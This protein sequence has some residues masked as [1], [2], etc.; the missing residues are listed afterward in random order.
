[1]KI[2]RESRNMFL[3]MLIG[4][5]Y[6]NPQGTMVLRHCYAQKEYLEFKKNLLNSVGIKTSEIIECNNNGYPGVYLY[7]RVYKFSKAYRKI[8]YTPKKNIAI[9]KLLNKLTPLGLAIWYMDDGGLSQKKKN[10]KVHANDLMLNTHLSKEENQ[11][12]IDYFKEVWNVQ[13]TQV[14]NKGKYRLRCG[15]K[16][17][18]KFIQIVE[19]HIKNI[20]CMLHKIDIKK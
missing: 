7:V 17:A 13:F 20:K 1:M 9:R 5:G 8:Y 2:N 15:T 19:P 3:F 6:I 16:E 12:I 4:D 10:G 14:K 11:I 18:R